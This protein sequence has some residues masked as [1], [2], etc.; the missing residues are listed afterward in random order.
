MAGK[1]Q[2]LPLKAEDILYIPGSRSAAYL[3]SVLA[4]LA[5]VSIYRL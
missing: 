3:G 4:T 5:A 1:A 2:D